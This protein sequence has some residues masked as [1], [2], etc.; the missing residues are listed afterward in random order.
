MTNPASPK[1]LQQ[2][3]ELRS[4][5][6]YF[7]QND[8]R[9]HFGLDQA[10]KVDTVEIRWLSGHIDVLHDL[11]I[12]L[13]YTIQEGGVVLKAAPLTPARAKTS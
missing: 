6:S 10:K 9:L 2:T 3:E 4:G 5:G 13:S 1:P 7:S 11:K 8:L 12:N